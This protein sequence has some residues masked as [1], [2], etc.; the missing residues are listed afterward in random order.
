MYDQL[1][2]D[3]KELINKWVPAVEIIAEDIKNIE[4]KNAKLAHIV[5]LN[6]FKDLLAIMKKINEDEY[7]IDKNTRK[8]ASIRSELYVNSEYENVGSDIVKLIE[9]IENLLLDSGNIYQVRVNIK[10]CIQVLKRGKG[11]L[12]S[13]TMRELIDRLNQCIIK[14]NKIQD[15]P[16]HGI[17]L[18]LCEERGEFGFITQTLAMI[19]V[20]CNECEHIFE[21]SGNS[22]LDIFAPVQCP[23]CRCKDISRSSFKHVKMYPSFDTETVRTQ[24]SCIAPKC[25][26]HKPVDKARKCLIQ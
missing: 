25:T 2:G 4:D 21:A 13:K 20:K 6:R 23:Q 26:N 12:P 24:P 10:R 8:I 7:A 17:I 19:D 3:L 9:A 14:R 11:V 5:E 16:Q 1:R 18:N 22:A 15:H